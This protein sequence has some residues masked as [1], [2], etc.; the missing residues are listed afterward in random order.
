MLRIATPA[1]QIVVRTLVVYFGVYLGFRV[2]GKREIGQMT[3]FDLVLILLIANAVQNAMVGP[4]TSLPGGLIAAVVLLAANWTFAQAR[5]VSPRADRLFEGQPS[6]LV[7]NGKL[8]LGQ[9]RKQGLAEEDLEMAIREHGIG[10]LDQVRLAVLETDGAISVVP[11][12]SPTYKSRRRSRAT[13]R[14]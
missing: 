11:T 1:W 10:S 12:T 2:L 3:T 5:I 9:L 6:V 14:R 13:R 4:D 8:M 7:E